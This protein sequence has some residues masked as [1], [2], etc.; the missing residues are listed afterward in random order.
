MLIEEAT[1][2]W[3]RPELRSD[4]ARVFEHGRMRS[5]SSKQI[6][7][8]LEARKKAQPQ[9]LSQHLVAVVGTFIKLQQRRHEADYDHGKVWAKTDV[10]TLIT[11]VS[12]P[13]AQ[14]YLVSLPGTRPRSE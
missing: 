3:A 14:A 12:E 2:N 4:L 8:M 11:E 5:A 9:A 1:L 6:S 10:Q 7:V 13:A